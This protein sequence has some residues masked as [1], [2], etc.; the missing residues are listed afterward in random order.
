MAGLDRM[1]SRTLC[2]SVIFL[3]CL[4]CLRPVSGYLNSKCDDNMMRMPNGMVSLRTGFRNKWILA[5]CLLS[6]GL[7]SSA[8]AGIRVGGQPPDDVIRLF[9]GDR[10]TLTAQAVGADAQVHLHEEATGLTWYEGPASQMDLSAWLFR[11][12]DILL[13]AHWKDSPDAAA[14]ETRFRLSV[15]H[16]PQILYPG[17]AARAI[18]RPLDEAPLLPEAEFFTP[19]DRAISVDTGA[20]PVMRGYPPYRTAE[21]VRRAKPVAGAA[22]FRLPDYFH[23]PLADPSMTED[24]AVAETRNPSEGLSVAGFDA[25]L[26][27]GLLM[28]DT[29]GEY[30]FR[31]ESSVPVRLKVAGEPIESAPDTKD[32]MCDLKLSVVLDAALVPLEIT[33]DRRGHP[34]PI[35]M[36]LSWKRPGREA[37]EPL[38]GSYFLHEVAPEVE[39]AYRAYR[40][41]FK[42]RAALSIARGDTSD[43]GAEALL[44]SVTGATPG[45]KEDWIQTARAVFDLY[46]HDKQ[47]AGSPQ[48][49]Q[50][51]LTHLDRSTRGHVSR[52]GNRLI[53]LGELSGFFEAAMRNPALQRQALETRAAVAAYTHRFYRRQWPCGFTRNFFNEAQSGTNDGYYDRDNFIQNIWRIAEVWDTP[54]AFDAARALFD[55]HFAYQADSTEGMHADGIY[56]FHTASGRHVNML[57]YGH[58]WLA[59]MRVGSESLYGN[60]WGFTREQYRRVAEMILAYEWFFY[61]EAEAFTTAGRHTRTYSGNR[62]RARQFLRSANYLLELP[63]DALDA[64]TRAQ[65]NAKVTRVEADRNIEGNR[66]FYRHLQMMHKRHDY[67]IDVKM[68]SPLTSAGIEC[69]AGAQPGSP[70]FGDGVT[71]LLRHGDEYRHLHRNNIPESLWRYRSLPGTTQLDY[72]YG[73]RHPYRGLD[74]YRR[75]EGSR[76]GGVSDGQFGHCAFEFVSAGPNATQARKMFTFTEDGMLVLGAG[77]TGNREPPAKIYT[78]RTNLNQCDR[79]G[80]VRLVAADKTRIIIGAEVRERM[81]ML[82]MTQAYWITHGDVGYLALP[83]GSEKGQGRKGYLGI[84]VSVRNPINRLGDDVWAI[85]RDDMREYREQAEALTTGDT[86]READVFELWIDHG[87]LPPTDATCAYFVSMRPEHAPVE[88]WLAAPPARILANRTD[89]Q[90]VEDDNAGI[91]HAFFYEPGKIAIQGGILGTKEPASV[92][93]RR[94]SETDAMLR[95]QDPVAACTQDPQEVSDLIRITLGDPDA[96]RTYSLTMPGAHDPDNRYRGGIAEKPVSLPLRPHQGR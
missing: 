93:I 36:L 15:E 76:A 22:A 57:G 4:V 92:M 53:F 65:L 91:V 54:I 87:H 8:S 21:S 42:H 48:V 50:V 39:A 51:L 58:D 26:I 9:T 71:T 70:S 17:L 60:P 32:T 12:E 79:K 49:A 90:A 59:R 47:L 84:R 37:F 19:G 27:H 82:P 10:L 6:G 18:R 46:R 75:G 94:L 61:E 7:S 83:T 13:K 86:A 31:I 78:Y 11:S 24:R 62:N 2:Y 34:G 43:P 30:G 20:D 38:D 64:E 85:D 95:V 67:H 16:G 3:G 81:L 89:V 74:R 73:S 80:A 14:R 23:L 45:E 5:L 77:I 69:F 28:A 66:F 72:E 1:G 96:P 68:N 88:A 63:E 33:I 52:G 29:A 41:D 55:S 25:L 40:D 44:A 35:T 56:S